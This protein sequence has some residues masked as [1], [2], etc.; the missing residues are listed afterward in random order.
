[1]KQKMKKINLEELK[2]KDLYLDDDGKIIVREKS[3]SKFVPLIEE[4][5][6]YLNYDYKIIEKRYLSDC[7][8]KLIL[9]K[10]YVFATEE[11]AEEYA[12]YFKALEK[13]RY[14]FSVDE[15][16]NVN[17]EKYFVGYK[18]DTDRM[19]ACSYCYHVTNKILFKTK[20][21][22]ENFIEEAGKENIKKFMFD[23]WE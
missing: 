21:D 2:D 23:I 13:Y 8:D 10:D 5:Y 22:C 1:M 18:I 3:N 20:S 11:E 7:F 4:K 17:I 16:K 9:S 12:K 6:Y 19:V 14:N 15:I